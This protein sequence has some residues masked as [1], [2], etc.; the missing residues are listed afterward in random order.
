[1]VQLVGNVDIDGMQT[2]I[3]NGGAKDEF[4]VGGNEG[5]ACNP[6]CLSG[7]LCALTGKVLKSPNPQ[8]F[9]NQEVSL[10]DQSD[11]SPE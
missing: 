3:C 2:Y 11:N 8:V 7:G 4:F 1:M 9:Q 10:G 6:N 5:P